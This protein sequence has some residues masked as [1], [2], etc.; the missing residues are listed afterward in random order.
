N[1]LGG[2]LVINNAKL[3]NVQ[4]AVGV[5]GGP[6]VLAGG[7]KIIA[8]WGQGNVFKG[9]NTGA[10]FTQGDIFNPSE[11]AGPVWMIGT[12]KHWF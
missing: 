7:T 2:S 1:N 3:N 11:S 5:V 8:S 9:T 6:T 12:G 10:T 4:I